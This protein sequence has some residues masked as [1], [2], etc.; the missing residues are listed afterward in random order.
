MRVFLEKNRECATKTA[1]ASVL[2]G[3]STFWKTIYNTSL[4]SLKAGLWLAI[5]RTRFLTIVA[6][7]RCTSIA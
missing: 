6:S 3:K 7:S 5:S 4:A 2:V 1:T